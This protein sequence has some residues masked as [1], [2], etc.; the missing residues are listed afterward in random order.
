MGM[1]FMLR[2]LMRLRRLNLHRVVLLG[3]DLITPN[4]LDR[5]FEKLLSYLTH[6]SF[7]MVADAELAR[8][9]AVQRGVPRGGTHR[10]NTKCVF[11]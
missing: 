11:M 8:V 6:V 9:Q 7:R 2:Q 10:R 1:S 3:T 4:D 5:E